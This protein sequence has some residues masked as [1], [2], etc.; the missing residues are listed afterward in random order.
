MAIT[1]SATD[2]AF[3][4]LLRQYRLEAR[5]SQEA[6]AERAMMSADGISA[7]ERGTNRAPQ[8]ETLALIVQALDLDPERQ[9]TLEAAAVRPVRPRSSRGEIRKQHNLP[10]ALTHF[11]GREHE[12]EEVK[13]L[14]TSSPLITLTGA[15]GVGKT[16]LAT[17]LAQRLLSDEEDGAWFVDLAAIRDPGAVQAAIAGVFG[18]FENPDRPLIDA[19]AEALERKKLLLIL[20]NCEHVVSAA[21]AAVERIAAECR[22]VR[23][24]ATSRQPLGIAGEQTYR[25]ASLD[26][27]ASVELFSETARRADP[28]FSLD[29]DIFT[30]GRICQRLD[31]IA[32]A[33]EL[34]AARVRLLSVVQIEELLS[35]RF[36]VLTGGGSLERHQTMR[37]LVD[38]SYDLLAPHEQLLFA[39]L[40]I[41]PADFSFEAALAVCAGATIRESQMLDVLGSLVDKSLLT[42]ER[43]GRARRFRLLETMRAY[44]LEKLGAAIHEFSARHAQY[45]L[46]LVESGDTRAHEWHDALELEYDNLR[47]ALDWAIDENGDVP[48]G[49]RLLAGM[50]EFV[51]YRGL[52]ADAARRAGRALTADASLPKT[53]QAMAWETMAAMRGDLLMPAAAFEASSQALALYEELEDFGGVARALRGRGVAYMRLGNFDQAD[54]DLQRSLELSKMYDDAR[55]VARTLG[56]IAVGLEMRGRPQEGRQAMLQV[57]KIARQEGD[58]RIIS[59]SLINLAESEFALGDAESA[60]SRLEELLASRAAQKNVRLR[61]NTKANLAVY[62]LAQHRDKDALRMA[63]EAVFDAR[64]AGD[65]GIEACAIQHV[66]AML[67]SAEPRTAAKLLGYVDA[68]F[69]AGY[70]RE[71]TERHTH[72]LLVST[73]HEELSDDA[74]ESLGR[75]G[76]TMSELQ[77]VRLATCANRTIASADRRKVSR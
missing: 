43:R 45:Y 61:A 21:A 7:L 19:I 22:G 27:N 17:E 73:L 46:K 42:S 14:V 3:G 39:R 10:H 11:Y 44:A 48:L 15:G 8:R 40:A 20:D 70:R 65:S 36:A 25:L 69:A 1:R 34:A 26:L 75:E 24:L 62:L 77:A 59:V 5:L 29:A 52:G 38:W 9:Q 66:A 23:I 54:A 49:I 55:G 47:R 53:L 56:S 33:I 72:S 35:Q 63:R 51:L 2:S 64:E 16:R 71:N 50:R 31:G 58:E 32:L 74:T 13:R 57:L 68:V 30:V 6:L 4:K 12:L 28:S 37:A 18:I 67:S 41:F 60:A 76:A